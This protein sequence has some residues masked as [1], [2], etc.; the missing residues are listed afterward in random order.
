MPRLARTPTRR[1]RNVERM[2]PTAGTQ[3][4][5]AALDRRDDASL[6]AL[7]EARPDLATPAPSSLTSLAARAASRP[8][9]ERALAGLN[10]VE[11]AVAETVTALAP[12][13][14]ADREAVSRA[15]GLD[16][17]PA[18]ARLEDLALTVDAAPLAGLPE[19]LGPHPAGLGP[20]LAELDAS[21]EQD[22]PPAPTDAE[23]L[24]AVLDGA[25]STAVRT[26]EALTWG[27]PVGTTAQQV[28]EGADWLLTHGVLRRLSPTQLVLPR[29]V[30]LAA[31][32]CRTWREPPRPPEPDY[33]S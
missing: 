18:L 6:A 30:G 17:G 2:A 25:P 26:L 11:L 9:V 32:E 8:S 7:L 5:A 33:R 22:G 13:D 21:F 1:R 4:L 23:S 29:E 16:A 24:R 15:V 28:P 10:A 20:T 27:P 3:E 31:R 12:L 14:R 19:A